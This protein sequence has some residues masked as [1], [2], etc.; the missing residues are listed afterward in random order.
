[1]GWTTGLRFPARARDFPLLH[2][3]HIGLG[4]HP[5]FC[6]TDIGVPTP[7]IWRPRREIDHSPPSSFEVKNGEAIPPLPYIFMALCLVT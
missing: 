5:V 3:V 1:M 6:L 4:A 2:S 7:G